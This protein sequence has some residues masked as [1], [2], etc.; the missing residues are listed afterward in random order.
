MTIETV[1]RIINLVFVIEHLILFSCAMGIGVY[2]IEQWGV[3][4]RGK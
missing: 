3:R 1:Q 2:Y 4:R